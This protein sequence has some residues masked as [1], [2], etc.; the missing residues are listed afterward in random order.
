M[1]SGSV[2]SKRAVPY[3]F[4]D[5]ELVLQ[6][7]VQPGASRTEW[8]GMHGERAL[9]LRI[10]APPLD[11]RANQECVR[12]L[13]KTAGVPKSSVTLLR[14]EHARDKTVRIAPLDDGQFQALKKQWSS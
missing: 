7:H 4:L 8:A 9:K 5:N 3:K 10:A 14:G 13:A 11:G 2:K 1:D 12:F 6:L